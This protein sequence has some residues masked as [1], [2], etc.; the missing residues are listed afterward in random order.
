MDR[1]LSMQQV[2]DGMGSF[3]SAVQAVER[4]SLPR[5]DTLE[6]LANA[7][8]VSPAWLAF[9]EGQSEPKRRRVA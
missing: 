7:L 3:A 6:Q 9:G 2:G 4:G 1:G 8:G 5:L